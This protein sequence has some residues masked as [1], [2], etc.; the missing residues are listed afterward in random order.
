MYF[1]LGK[2]IRNWNLGI[3]HMHEVHE[4]IC[5]MLKTLN[6]LSLFIVSS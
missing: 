6:F 4:K 3:R 1:T 5:E 2:A